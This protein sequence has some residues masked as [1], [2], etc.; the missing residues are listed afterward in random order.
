M[1]NRISKQTFVNI[2]CAVL[3][4]T[5]LVTVYR[6]SSNIPYSDDFNQQLESIHLLQ[7]GELNLVDL[8]LRQHNEHRLFTTYI[9]TYSYYFITGLV[10]LKVSLIISVFM[11]GGIWLTLRKLIPEKYK[12]ELTLITALIIF[13]PECSSSV[14]V[15]GSIQ[16]YGVV[17]FGLL[18]ILSLMKQ[19]SIINYGL[20]VIC[21]FLALY[22]M[23]AGVLIFV[24]GLFYLLVHQKI[25]NRYSIAW[26]IASVL[27]MILYFGTYR[28]PAHH[29][30]TLYFLENPIFTLQYTFVL[31][32]AF[33]HNQV[34][35]YFLPFLT[36]IVSGIFLYISLFKITIT[37]IIKDKRFYPFLYFL[38]VLGSI[39]AGRAGLE[40]LG[41]AF[42]DRY[43]IYTKCLWI[44]ALFLLVNHNYFGKIQ[45]YVT[46]GITLLF[47]SS[48]YNG[49]LYCLADHDRRLNASL[50]DHLFEN[51]SNGFDYPNKQHAAKII[52]QAIAAGYYQPS[53]ETQSIYQTTETFLNTKNIHIH[54][55]RIKKVN[56][57]A[58]LRGWTFVRNRSSKQGSI[59]IGFSQQS[60]NQPSYALNATPTSRPDVHDAHGSDQFNFTES[61]FKCI[62]DL[63]KLESSKG[64][65]YII[66]DEL[67]MDIT[68]QLLSLN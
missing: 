63:S 49:N 25:R 60:D 32:G 8:L 43:F 7:K 48:H 45:L 18:S 14:W 29:P 33:L 39:V 12:N 56:G 65:Y 31:L 3:F 23:I 51:Q 13:V 30:S 62:I 50:N 53:L 28:S 67:Y 68:N 58:Y 46:L 55:D 40:E 35:N 59:K 9:F 20:S 24:V 17:L 26:L 10:D 27:I 44:L 47:C 34:N 21:F 16:Y 42:A 36:I 4:C 54:L 64:R 15:G 2:I 66:I 41:Q 11:L 37:T 38:L 1:T 61:G 57:Y 5:L 52:D 22:S 19:P 6:Y